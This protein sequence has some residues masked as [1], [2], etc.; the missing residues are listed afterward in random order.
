[1]HYLGIVTTA[2]F[3]LSAILNIIAYF[4]RPGNQWTLISAI[5]FGIVV[6][7]RI[8]ETIEDIREIKQNRRHK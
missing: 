8:P 1:M 3:L 7:L 5:G 2:L 6:L 4:V